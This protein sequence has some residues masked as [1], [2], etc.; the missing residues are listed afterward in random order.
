MCYW[1]NGR[2]LVVIPPLIKT[3]FRIDRKDLDKPFFPAEDSV[4]PSSW[5]KSQVLL[6]SSFGGCLPPHPPSS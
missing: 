5:V 2:E 6:Q 4:L 3:S 1:G